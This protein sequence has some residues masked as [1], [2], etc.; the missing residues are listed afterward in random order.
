MSELLGPACKDRE[1][2]GQGVAGAEPLSGSLLGGAEEQQEAQ[3][4]GWRHG[5]GGS[6]EVR[7]V[8]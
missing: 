5:K 6:E 3:V 8:G 1:W 4:V 7:E 2:L